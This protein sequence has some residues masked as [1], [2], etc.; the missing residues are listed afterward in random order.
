M[1]T[2]LYLKDCPS[3]E[4]AEKF[5]IDNGI[6]HKI[7][8]FN[9][10]YV[11]GKEYYDKRAFKKEYGNDATFPRIYKGKEYIG[12]YDDLKNHNF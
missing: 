10:K 3:S 4:A 8:R 5:F 9:D 2:I 6:E 7:Y 1:Y 12:G 11:D